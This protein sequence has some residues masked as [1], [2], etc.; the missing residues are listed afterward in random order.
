MEIQSR[1]I[2]G[3]VG[4]LILLAGPVA[5]ASSWSGAAASA[6]NAGNAA[7]QSAVRSTRDEIARRAMA[8]QQWN[9]EL[10]RPPRHNHNHSR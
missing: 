9:Y 1:V 6:S 7:A 8:Q 3:C 10:R 2:G 5:Q 4:A